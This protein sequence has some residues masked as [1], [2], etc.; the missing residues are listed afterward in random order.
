MR[1]YG[2]EVRGGG[3][4]AGR[5]GRQQR[6]RQALEPTARLETV[7]DHDGGS[8]WLYGGL[9]GGGVVRVVLYGVPDVAGVPRRRR[10][11]CRRRTVHRQLLTERRYSLVVLQLFIRR[12]RVHSAGAR[13]R[14]AKRH[15]VWRSA[16]HSILWRGLMRR[17]RQEGPLRGL[18]LR[19][20]AQR[21]GH[22]FVSHLCI[23]YV[24]IG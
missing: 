23:Y 24:N 12:R 11:H 3:G 13:S 8:Q 20:R 10:V 18:R 2:G 6:L 14:A 17:C 16:R 7:R 5:R 1:L 15:A 21:R 22:F 19:I 9:H 4:H